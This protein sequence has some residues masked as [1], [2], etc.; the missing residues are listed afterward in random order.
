MPVWFSKMPL[1]HVVIGDMLPR[2]SKAAQ[3]SKHYTNHC[4]RATSIVLI[5]KAG[6]DDRAVCNI[7]G[8]KNVQSLDSYCCP[9][10]RE[11]RSLSS[12]LDGKTA[13]CS[14]VSTSVCSLKSSCEPEEFSE[15]STYE[16]IFVQGHPGTAQAAFS[17]KKTVFKHVTF[18]FGAGEAV[19]ERA[20]AAR[21]MLKIRK[22]K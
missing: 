4:V 5:K 11:I 19:A 6:F 12:A 9:S 10:E 7:P 1:G 16:S 20:R 22:K 21:K 8:H 18:N 3:L 13:S 17:S 14:L 2:I 15:M